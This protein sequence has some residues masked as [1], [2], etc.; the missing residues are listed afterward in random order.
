[1][2]EISIYDAILKAADYIETHPT[3]FNMDAIR[4][5]DSATPPGCGTPGC[6]LGWISHFYGVESRSYGYMENIKD[7]LGIVSDTDFYTRMKRVSKSRGAGWCGY[8]LW[9][10]NAKKCAQALRLYAAKYHAPMCDVA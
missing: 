4:V 9:T 5:P 2:E 8:G 6:A 7:P 3:R 1:M 10:V